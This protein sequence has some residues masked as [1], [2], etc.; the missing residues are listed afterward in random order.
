MPPLTLL[1]IASLLATSGQAQN[2][3]SQPIRAT[4]KLVSV[5]ALVQSS[6]GEL[7]TTLN[8][9]DF[10]LT[11]NG[12]RQALSLDHLEREPLAVMVLLQIGGA[13]V[14]QLPNYTGLGAMLDGI[15]GAS[16]HRV[17][18]VTFDSRPEEAWDF[19]PHIDD[20]NDGFTHPGPGDDG[21][22]ILDAVSL[23]IDSLRAEPAAVRRILILISQGQDTG[24]KAHLDEIIRRLGESDITIFSITFSPE[25]TWLKDQ[26]TK[27]RHGNKPYQLSPNSQPLIGTFDLGTPI[28]V[29]LSAM[30][31][32][33]AAEAANLSGGE[34]L[35]F[36][37]KSDLESKLAALANSIHNRYALS[38][39][40]NPTEPGFHTLHLAIPAQPTLKVAARTSYWMDPSAIEKLSAR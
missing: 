4:S 40:P 15:V 27:P 39:S 16:A 12:V 19:T 11:D 35:E 23:G 26:F 14:R 2:T 7:V 9:A 38:F 30:R 18:L 28:A 33:T 21:A 6:S 34:H 20:I 32:N 22:A 24:S 5:P 13:A 36:G 25:K 3:A 29:A 8:A 17:S 31:S 1:A 10:R 37:N